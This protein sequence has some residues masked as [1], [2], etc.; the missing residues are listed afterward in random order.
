MAITYE[1]IQ[2]YTLGSTSSTI[3]FSSI[4]ATY[5]DLRVTLTGTSTSAGAGI[6]L[7]FNGSTGNCSQTFLL[8]NGTSATTGRRTSAGIIALNDTGMS[9]TIPSFYSIDIFSYA[10]SA[11]KTCLITANE[12]RNGSGTVERRVGLWSNTAAITQVNLGA[13]SFAT[14]TTATLYGIKNA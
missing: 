14:G 8:G 11:F 10:G 5:T 7:Y 2:T 9:T 1:P 6:D 13:S 4:P 3:T 12:D